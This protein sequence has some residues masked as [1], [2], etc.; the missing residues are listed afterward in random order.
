M[1]RNL[2]FGL[3]DVAHGLVGC[4]SGYI[5]YYFF[6]SGYC[7]GRLAANA[8]A[9]SF[10]KSAVVL[11]IIVLIIIMSQRMLS[12]RAIKKRLT[13]GECWKCQYRYLGAK[14][15]ECGSTKEDI[16][17]SPCLKVSLY[18]IATTIAVL[19]LA[20][21]FAEYVAVVEERKF[22]EDASFSFQTITGVGFR[23]RRLWP[24]S[25][26]TMIAFPDGTTIVID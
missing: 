3:Y 22:L 16:V 4:V 9:A 13:R 1:R 19:M 7:N 5:L 26:L 18:R 14:C 10:T 25:H 12:V 2:S 11:L 15:S 23:R 21:V 20:S 17:T 8:Y 6:R 24:S